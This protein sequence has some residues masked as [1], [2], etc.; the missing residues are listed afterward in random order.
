MMTKGLDDIYISIVHADFHNRLKP[1]IINNAFYN[2]SESVDYILVE[3]K[4]NPLI[5]LVWIGC[6]LLILGEIF[7]IG[8]LFKVKWRRSVI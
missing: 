2:S 3:V 6:T 8:T 1:I 4:Y 7:T 5:Q